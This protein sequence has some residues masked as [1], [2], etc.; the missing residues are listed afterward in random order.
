MSSLKTTLEGLV[1]AGANKHPPTRASP[2][3]RGSGVPIVS[4]A[5]ED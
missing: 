2:P 1:T 5:T 3:K 4:V